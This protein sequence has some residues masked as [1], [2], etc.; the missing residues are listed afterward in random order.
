M[1]YETCLQIFVF[2]GGSN[3]LYFLALTILQLSITLWVIVRKETNF[4]A[5]IFAN[6]YPSFLFVLL[7]GA[8]I[9]DRFQTTSA[10]GDKYILEFAPSIVV[11]FNMLGRAVSAKVGH[12]GLI[13]KLVVLAC[14]FWQVFVG[15]AFVA[16]WQL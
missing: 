2:A 15:F 10:V 13:N 16:F 5:I 11:V 7:S 1:I 3:P 4:Y 6:I 8:E 12:L 9:V 14:S